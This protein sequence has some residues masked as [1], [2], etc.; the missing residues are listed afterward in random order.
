MRIF[1]FLYSNSHK[2]ELIKVIFKGKCLRMCM[3]I[4][5]V[6][7]IWPMFLVILLY[8]RVVFLETIRI[9]LFVWFSILLFLLIIISWVFPHIINYSSKYMFYDYIQ[10]QMN[11]KFSVLMT[12]WLWMYHNLILF[13]YTFVLWRLV[14]CTYIFVEWITMN[15]IVKLC[16]CVRMYMY[17][18]V[19]FII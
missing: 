5:I 15:C 8:T 7:L 14:S 11:L 3:Y 10:L 19:V 18:C 16:V 13:L 6:L 1:S 2:N 17:V 4:C 9:M 12:I